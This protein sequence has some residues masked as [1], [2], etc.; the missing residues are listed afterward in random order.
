VVIGL[1][2]I[3]VGDLGRFFYEP[4]TSDDHTTAVVECCMISLA[5]D[6][7]AEAAVEPLPAAA[8]GATDRVRPGAKPPGSIQVQ[9]DRI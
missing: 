8:L 1:G 3:V 9:T 2:K 4:A 6:V 7:P 5:G